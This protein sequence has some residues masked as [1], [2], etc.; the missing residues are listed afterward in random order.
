M[1]INTWTPLYYCVLSVFPAYAFDYAFLDGSHSFFYRIDSI[2]VVKDEK[3]KAHKCY[4]Q[5]NEVMESTLMVYYFKHFLCKAQPD[6]TRRLCTLGVNNLQCQ[7][8]LEIKG[9][10]YNY[11]R[12][13]NSVLTVRIIIVVRFEPDFVQKMHHLAMQ[14]TV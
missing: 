12:E 2:Y 10:L 14:F 9:K 4:A 6:L 8:K 7:L 13:M 3:T 5:K 1:S 11:I